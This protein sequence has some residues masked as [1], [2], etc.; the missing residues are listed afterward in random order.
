MDIEKV[1][2]AVNE[3][4]MLLSFMTTEPIKDFP[5]TTSTKIK[6]AD[7]MHLCQHFYFMYEKQERLKKTLD[8]E[9]I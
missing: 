7:T 5:L 3:A 4:C 6:L 8:S 2:H 1:H 9:P